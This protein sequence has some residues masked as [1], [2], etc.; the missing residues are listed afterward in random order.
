MPRQVKKDAEFL[1]S[2]IE[3]HHGHQS[4]WDYDADYR[5][6]KYCGD[7]AAIEILVK[8][9]KSYAPG[10]ILIAAHDATC[11]SVKRRRLSALRYLK[12]QG[13]LGSTY[14]G[15]WLFGVLT[16]TNEYYLISMHPW[17]TQ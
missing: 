16:R 5:F 17:I 9:E 8:I 12:K 13:I 14:S 4:T 11:K 3:A 6:A 2:D 7:I 15:F 1:L 10:P